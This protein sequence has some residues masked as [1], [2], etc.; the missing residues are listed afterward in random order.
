[1][2]MDKIFVTFLGVEVS[3]IVTGTIMLIFALNTQ[4]AESQPF[5]V[6]NVARDLLL[7]ECPIRGSYMHRSALKSKETC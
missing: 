7:Q 6:E 1:M 4:A 5:T 2:P 3:F